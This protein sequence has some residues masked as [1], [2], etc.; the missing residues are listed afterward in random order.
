M[1]LVHNQFRDMKDYYEE[2][3][4]IGDLLAACGLDV[5]RQQLTDVVAAGFTATEILSGVWWHL[6]RIAAQYPNLDAPLRARI[7]VLVAVLDKV[8]H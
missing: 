3:R 2:T 7:E 8:L 6:K 1:A 4:E 5:E